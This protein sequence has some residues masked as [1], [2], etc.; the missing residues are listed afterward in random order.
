MRGVSA[1]DEHSIIS[2]MTIP[3][4]SQTQRQGR[5]SRMGGTGKQNGLPAKFGSR[6][7]QTVICHAMGQQTVN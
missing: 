3:S 5:F 7:V 6:R 2:E 1:A 4:H